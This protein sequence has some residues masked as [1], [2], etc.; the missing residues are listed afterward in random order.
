MDDSF[1]STC[2]AKQNKIE[3]KNEMLWPSKADAITD[4]EII[5]ILYEMK[6]FGSETPEY[7]V[8]SLVEQWHSF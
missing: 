5:N 1:C 6:I 3:K 4:E 2:D 7:F 8:H